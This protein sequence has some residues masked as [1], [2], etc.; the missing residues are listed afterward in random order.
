MER[1]PEMRIFL[2]DT[3]CELRPLSAARVL[4]AHRESRRLLAEYGGDESDRALIE[5]ACLVAAGLYAD[6]RPVFPDGLEAL[7]SLTEEEI[8]FAAAGYA[9]NEGSG[10]A[11]PISDAAREES[12]ESSSAGRTAP[13][14]AESVTETPAPAPAAEETVGRLRRVQSDYPAQ[15]D[16]KRSAE[17]TA[18]WQKQEAFRKFGMLWMPFGERGEKP[19]EPSAPTPAADV[20][21][22]GETSFPET[23]TQRRG[24]YRSRMEEL[25]DFFERDSRRYDGRLSDE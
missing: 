5:S 1:E 17:K 2:M 8:A 19:R 15:R 3:E 22:A 14:K 18:A 12:G 10:A 4:E 25:S 6:D 11:R 20:T 24:R 9:G 21:E 7:L 23:G 13:E 16:A